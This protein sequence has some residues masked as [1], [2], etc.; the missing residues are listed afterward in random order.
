[1]DDPDM[2]QRIIGQLTSWAKWYSLLSI[3]NAQSAIDISFAIKG[4]QTRDPMARVGK[5]DTGVRDGEIVDVLLTN[6]SERDLYVAILDLSTDGSVTIA[7]PAGQGVAEVLRPGQ[8]LTRSLRAGV[9]NGRKFVVDIL[10]AFVSY[11]PIN[12]RPITQTAIRDIEPDSG[13][14]D[15]LQQLL[16]DSAGQTRG[17][18]PILADSVNLSPWTTA[19]LTLRVRRSN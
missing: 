9:P 17:L 5:P 6:K 11:H 8:T 19:Q 18:T 10:K 16:A 13:D 12:L 3:Q 7:Y 2:V 4:S 14:M 15:P 1:L